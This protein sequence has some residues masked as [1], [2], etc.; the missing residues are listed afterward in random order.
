MEL[1]R[2]VFRK[3]AKM[4]ALRGSRG[5]DWREQSLRAFEGWLKTHESEVLSALAH[6]L[7]KPEFE[8]FSTEFGFVLGEVRHTLREF[9]VWAA[10]V[11]C[12]T[13]LKLQ[14][15]RSLMAHEPKGP[16]LILVPWNYPFQLAVAPMVA[17]LAAGN[18]VVIKPS[19]F[20]PRT[21]ALLAD[22][23]TTVWPEGEVQV[24]LGDAAVAEELVAQE[25]AHVFFTGSENVGRRVYEACASRLIPVTLELGGKSPCVIDSDVDLDVTLSRVLWGK[26]LNAGQT[27]VAPDYLLVHRALRDS[28]LVSVKKKLREF[29]GEDP[30]QSPSL[31]CLVSERHLDRMLKLLSDVKPDVGGR[32]DRSRRRLEPTVVLEPEL[33]SP[34]MQEEIFGPIL[35]VL[36][37]ETDAELDRILR[38]LHS[39]RRHPLAFYVFSRRVRWAKQ[40]MASH[41]FGG[42]AVND[43]VLYMANPDLPFGG[44]GR[45][46]FGAY[47]GAFGFE[48]FSSRK[49]IFVRRGFAFD[50]PIRYPP[51]GDLW[52]RF[53]GLFS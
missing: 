38:E 50:L 14:P 51:Y 41:R 26:F 3:C 19:E 30:L 8:A 16:T 40:L 42:G 35:P 53:K 28:F 34:L 29:Y 52:R 24:V 36:F 49:A 23:A 10:P 4:D 15:G 5:L 25:W 22:M 1:A 6:D 9:R 48:A 7:G 13:P 27:C 31:A 33:A 18:C 2:E 17:A 39:A 45:S 20:A 46:G 11:S 43:V 47:H 44:V 37:W 32:F 12:P 21:A